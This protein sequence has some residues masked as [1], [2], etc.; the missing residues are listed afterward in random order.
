M[1]IS[2]RT[3]INKNV[4]YAIVVS[5]VSANF[6]SVNMKAVVVDFLDNGNISSISD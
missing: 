3:I 5:L 2:F 1:F 4:Y 6:F